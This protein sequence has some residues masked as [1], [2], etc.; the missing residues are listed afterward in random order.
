MLK[1]IIETI[2]YEK[3]YNTSTNMLLYENYSYD[4]AIK[5][6]I[7]KIIETDVFTYRRYKL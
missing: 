6:G 2:F 3:D 5:K 1:E 4:E 7:A